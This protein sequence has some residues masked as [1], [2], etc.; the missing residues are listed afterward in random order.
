MRL[1]ADEDDGRRPTAKHQPPLK[2]RRIGKLKN[3]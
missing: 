1:L 2:A 3:R